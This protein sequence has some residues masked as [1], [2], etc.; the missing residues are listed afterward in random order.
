ME[1]ERRWSLSQGPEVLESCAPVPGSTSAPTW[2]P[3]LRGPV[4]DLK[5]YKVIGVVGTVLLVLDMRRSQTFVIKVLHKS[6][7]GSSAGRPSVV[8]QGV[9]HMAQLLCLYET[10]CSYFLV[11]EY[12]PGGRLWD[13]LA[14]YFTNQLPFPNRAREVSYTGSPSSP[15]NGSP[16]SPCLPS[17]ELAAKVDLH[18]ESLLSW[19]TAKSVSQKTLVYLQQLQTANLYLCLPQN[20]LK[21]Q[22]LVHRLYPP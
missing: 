14:P 22:S 20:N 9:P 21:P 19:T 4:Q 8:P 6:P 3:G 13:C 1:G 11:L 12:A 17:G 16:A 15:S 2:G 10:D 5:H 7:G 18:Y